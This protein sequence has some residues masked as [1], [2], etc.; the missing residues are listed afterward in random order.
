MNLLPI[1]R[2][3]DIIIQDLDKELLIY[4]LITNQAFSLNETSKVVFNSCDGKTSFEELKSEYKFSDDLIYLALDELNNKSLLED[5]Y[6][7]PLT[8]MTRRQVIRKVGLTSM[9]A[10][11]VISTLVAP[12]ATMAQ[13]ICVGIGAVTPG[14][15]FVCAVEGTSCQ[16][17]ASNYCTTCNATYIPNGPRCGGTHT[18]ECVCAA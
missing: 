17:F 18:F 2:Q 16:I 8:A 11:P 6:Y 15:P 4:N 1:A 9:I 7:S 3:S 13:S 12:T 5:S 14:N 10:L